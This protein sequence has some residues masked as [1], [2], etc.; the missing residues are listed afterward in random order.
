MTVRYLFLLAIIGGLIGCNNPIIPE[1]KRLL[2]YGASGR[3]GGHIVQEALMRG[4]KVSGVTRDPSRLEGK[5]VG[6]RVI[7]GDILD[8]DSL[9]SLVAQH[10]AVLVSVGGPPANEDPSQYIAALAAKSLIQVLGSMEEGSPRVLFVG[11]L[12]T[13]ED[14][15]GQTFLVSR[16]VPTTHRNYAMFHG[17]Q[18]ALD[19][20]RASTNIKWTVASPPNGLRLKERTGNIRWGD[21]KLL[22][23]ADGKPSTISPQDFAYSI[24]E[25]LEAER[26]INKRYTVAQ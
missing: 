13:L 8:R 2:I 19:I 3:I 20:F 6:L 16:N 23:D 26:Y 18:L 11:N 9:R 7:Q 5:Y 10:D 21:D 4:Y 15:S 17:H 25:E 14:E 12:Y 22:L 24:L 1:Q